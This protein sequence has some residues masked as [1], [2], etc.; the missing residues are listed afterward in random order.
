MLAMFM[1]GI[2][3][4]YSSTANSER[5]KTAAAKGDAQRIEIMIPPDL[6]TFYVV[7]SPMLR[8][9]PLLKSYGRAPSVRILIALSASASVKA[10]QI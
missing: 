1:A 10:A 9:S 4:T 2:V 7:N 3:T 5:G 6:R 8:R